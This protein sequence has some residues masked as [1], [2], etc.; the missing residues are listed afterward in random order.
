ML[1]W[2]IKNGVYLLDSVH[3]C[4]QISLCPAYYIICANLYL[5]N[6]IMCVNLF[7]QPVGDLFKPNKFWGPALPKHRKLVLRYVSEDNFVVDPWEDEAIH[8][9][10]IK[11]SKCT[12]SGAL[13]SSRKAL[14]RRHCPVKI[15]LVQCIT[16][17]H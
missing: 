5:T 16:P 1:L 6:H 11:V 17:Y 4:W 10:Q 8:M 9:D 3:K 12:K 2:N 7:L 13:Q 15:S 14:D